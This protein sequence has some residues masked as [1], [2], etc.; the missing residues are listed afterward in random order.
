MEKVSNDTLNEL[1]E[2]FEDAAIWDGYHPWRQVLPC[3]L[4]L[5]Q[6]R[7]EKRHVCQKGDTTAKKTP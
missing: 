1:I 4:E 2:D 3:L 5:K 7:A 6:L